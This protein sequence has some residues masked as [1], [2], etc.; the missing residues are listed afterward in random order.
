MAETEGSGDR[1][2][3]RLGGPCD[4]LRAEGQVSFFAAV[5]QIAGLRKAGCHD[6]RGE[7]ARRADGSAG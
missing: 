2:S 4:E 5:V 6:I 1:A 3:H 7:A